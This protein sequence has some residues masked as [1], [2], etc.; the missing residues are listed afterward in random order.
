MAVIA[1]GLLVPEWILDPPK[2]RSM[3]SVPLFNWGNTYIDNDVLIRDMLA[4]IARLEPIEFPLAQM[5]G[6]W[7]PSERRS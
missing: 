2:G 4:Q 5:V 1:S 7:V 3:I 6:F